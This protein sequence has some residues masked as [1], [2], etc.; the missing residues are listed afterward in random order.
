MQLD[1]ESQ[2][3]TAFT[4]PG[5]GQYHWIT[6]PMGL[7]GCPAS[8]QRLM[9]TVLRNISN[10]LVYIDDV[11]LHTATHEE[12]LKVLEK[13]F[14]RLHQNHLKV[15]LDKCVFGNKVVAYLGFM[16]TPEGIKPGRNKLQ[17]IRDAQPPTNIKM[18]RSFVGLC[19]F[20]RMHIKDFAILAAPLFKVT[21]K[22]SGYKSGPLPPDALHAFKVLQQ[23]LTSDPVMAFPR[24]D[25]QYALITDAATGSADFSGGLGAILTQMDKN[26][27]HYAI[28]FASRQ[29]KDH[30]KNYSPF[31]LEAAAA[32]WGMET[33]NEYLR[34]KQ[35]ILFTDHKPLEKLGHLHTKTLNR[36]QT[37]LLEHDFIVQYKKGRNMPADYLSRLPSLPINAVDTPEISAFDP[38]TPDLQL[39]QRKDQD[40]QAIFHFLKHNSWPE[41]LPKQTIRNLA[42]I[43]PK[44][45]F[46]KNKLAW[47]R[48]SDHNYPRT[49][50]WLPEQ[51]RKEALCETHDSI[52]AGHNAALKSYIKLTTSY[53]WPT[54]YSHVLKHIKTCL[55][56]QQRKQSKHKNLPLTPLP[57]PDMPNIRLHAD[58]L[59]PMVDANRK[60]AYILC[61]TD[62]FT[63]YAVVT[64]IPNKDAQ[65][66]AK[67]IF[68]Q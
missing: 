13:V 15:N 34:G 57:I 31:L 68:E 8:F 46:D 10:V 1:E 59:G 11:L 19:N 54:V 47:I 36:L 37:A 42:S 12:H 63:K 26:G 35:F 66:V 61:M 51:Y 27:N 25:R 30:E 49:A 18:V 48:L 56:C 7:L 21:R 20:F 55:R 45:F 58:L 41:H 43:A 65:T 9:E 64:S 29:L 24:A 28:S 67:V 62:A 53:Y 4:I 22:D 6:S 14:E 60:S 32:V 40:L 33:F 38:F 5:K 52:F 3:L 23:Q 2:P 17:A 39:L 50:L 16:L 44:V